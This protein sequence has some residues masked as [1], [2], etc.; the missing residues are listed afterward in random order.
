MTVAEEGDLLPL[1][2]TVQGG[3]EKKDPALPDP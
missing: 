1:L 2:G 3:G